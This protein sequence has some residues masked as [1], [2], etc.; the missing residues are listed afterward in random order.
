MNL[1]GG[2]AENKKK[3]LKK[4]LIISE[5]IVRVFTFVAFVILNKL[6]NIKVYN[7]CYFPKILKRFIL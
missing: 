7:V 4:F 3:Y 2:R 5:N 1:K 6:E